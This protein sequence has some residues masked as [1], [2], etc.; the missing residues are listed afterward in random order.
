MKKTLLAFILLFLSNQL[1]SDNTKITFDLKDYLEKKF[2][3][4]DKKFENVDKRFDKTDQ[5]IDDI[6]KEIHNIKDNHLAHLQNWLIGIGVTII[7]FLLINFLK[8]ILKK[9]KK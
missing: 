8:Q 6:N 1:F 2:E 9:K 3:N 7:T 5:K 4:V